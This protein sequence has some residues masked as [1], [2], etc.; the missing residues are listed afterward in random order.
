MTLASKQNLAV[1]GAHALA[2]PVLLGV[3]AGVIGVYLGWRGDDG[4]S[5]E[6]KLTPPGKRFLRW[7]LLGAV[8]VL[9]LVPF[10]WYPFI[11][12]LSAC[13]VA[14]AF[15]ELLHLNWQGKISRRTALVALIAALCAGQG[16]SHWRN[17]RTLRHTCRAPC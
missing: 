5:S 17:R 8:I 16:P 10:R 1:I 14:L 9:L 6:Q 12:V 3:L 2:Q 4:T 15:T 13:G 7:V 11:F